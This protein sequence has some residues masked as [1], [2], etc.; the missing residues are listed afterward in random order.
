RG[1]TT[2]LEAGPGTSL[3]T[4]ITT[5]HPDT[6][7]I[8]TQ[9]ENHTLATALATLHTHGT[10]I[11]WTTTTGNHLNLP[12]Y[13]FQHRHYWASGDAGGGADLRSA[14]L[15]AMS[16]PWLGAAIEVPGSGGIVVTGRVSVETH[17]WLA[18]HRVRGRVLFPV[19]GAL[20][21]AMT[22]AK[23]AGCTLVEDFALDKP[24]VL[25]ETSAAQLRAFADGADTAGRRAFSVHWRHERA[26]E[27]WNLL[28][29]GTLAPGRE[30]VTPM[31]WPPVADRVEVETSHAEL[32][33][34]GTEHGPAFRALRK[35]W[36]RGRELFAELR[37]PDTE[38]LPVTGF[39]IHPALVDVVAHLAVDA[40]PDAGDSVVL[41]VAWNSFWADLSGVS[42]L[43]VRVASIDGRVTLEADDQTGRPVLRAKE[44]RSAAVPAELLRHTSGEPVYDIDWI[45]FDEAEAAAPDWSW[46]SEVDTRPEEPVPAVVVLP[47]PVPAGGVTESVRAAANTV[48]TVLQRWSTE[49]RFA[50]ARLV[51]TTE[52][53]VFAERTQ[54]DVLIE[55]APVWGVV[56][57]AQ[58]EQPGR[59][60]LAD[61]DGPGGLDAVL[62][63]VA[64]SAE[65]EFAVRHGVVLVPRLG[66]VRP[67]QPRGLGSGC[68]LIT[69]GTGGV[70]AVLARHVVAEHGIRDLVLVSRRGMAADGAADLAAEL[71]SLG[72]AVEILAADVSDRAE[73]D[74]VVAGIG[75]R[76]TGVIHAAGASDNGMIDSLTPKRMEAVLAA[77]AH[78]AWHLHE[79]TRGLDLTAFVL[80]SS[81][82]AML[83]P[84]GMANYAAA[85]VFLDALAAKRHRMGLPAT[86]M[87][88]GLWG[89]G[90]GMGAR[91]GDQD[92]QRLR[93]Q[94][95]PVLDAGTGT[96]LFDAALASGRP[97]V[98]ASVLDTTVFRTGGGEVPA[99]LRGLVPDAVT[100]ARERTPELALADRLAE[101]GADEARRVVLDLVRGRTA[102]VL[103][104]PN[105]TAVAPHRTF[106]DLGIDS[107]TAVELR[108]QLN[109][110]TGRKLPATLAFDCPT[111]D[112]V[113]DH[114][115]AEL[116]P[117]P[118][119]VD[120]QDDDR[121]RAALQA[122]SVNQLRNAGLLE[123]L[124]ELA[125]VGGAPGTSPG[126]GESIDSLD[127]DALIGLVLDGDDF[128]GGSGV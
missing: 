98:I 91:T 106:L 55:C 126:G 60:V 61:L 13:P 20:D 97:A 53:A 48:L 57:A 103:G 27:H 67:A 74:R 3:S 16:H 17:P 127:V 26:D 28:A 116:A 104:Y 71:G 25:A 34:R 94:G 68:V 1:I 93:A 109:A 49:P 83:V 32:S 43:R 102:A 58:A 92:R 105:A 114:I 7:T 18:E 37:L 111:A 108:N 41:P 110:A 36:R 69:G 40:Q 115:L 11:T 73:V 79:A 14:G 62:G 2:F 78:S 125:G 75:A 23:M 118:S 99:L 128:D 59:F 56:R 6:T 122:V 22:V 117:D 90:S 35:M 4:A 72:A 112:A 46:W 86:S 85:N 50:A 31:R 38:H 30:S 42:A 47:C 119:Q 70:A 29:H 96:A 107:L 101:L 113:T 95:L 51:V 84:G 39:A 88:F 45:P 121:V 120:T 100:V 5:S 80:L 82:G 52:N 66:T 123:S 24:L 89:I 65:P 12:T 76:L 77:K 87:A 21:L 54:V 9:S 64:D 19:T 63:A 81:V 44:V 10:P 124:L 8:P 15:D 33:A